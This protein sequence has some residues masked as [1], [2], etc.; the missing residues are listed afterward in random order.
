MKLQRHLERQTSQS[1]PKKN[2]IG[3]II[4]P[5][6]RLYYKSTVIETVQYQHEKQT[7]KLMEEN[8][9]LRNE[10][11]PYQLI[12]DKGAKKTQQ[13]KDSFFNKCC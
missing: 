2:R 13:R 12:F 4:I 3:S 7:H 9:E 6:F 11:M 5:D 10:S 1:N 8:R